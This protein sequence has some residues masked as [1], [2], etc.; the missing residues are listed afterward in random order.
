[1]VFACLANVVFAGTIETGSTGGGQAHNNRQSYL[2]MNHLVRLQGTDD[3][4][5]EIG[6]FA[7]NFAPSGWALADGQILQVSQ[8]QA[9]HSKLGFTYGGN[10]TTTFA[11]PDLR[12]RT[13]IGTGQGF[14]M[15]NRPLGTQ[16]GTSTVSLSTNQLPSHNHAV[17]GAIGG[18][19]TTVGG[20]QSHN[21][22]MPS[23]ALTQA[24][25]LT[26]LIPSRGLT[27]G[28]TTIDSVSTSPFI[29]EIRTYAG[30]S[31][32]TGFA[33]TNGQLLPI[34]QNSDLFS[35][36]GTSYGGDGETTTGLPNLQGRTAMHAGSGPGLT[37][38]KI[39]E[40]GGRKMSR[41]LSIK[42]HF[43]LTPF[44]VVIL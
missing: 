8:F 19:T 16:V 37:P 5:G 1:M 21:N 40:T 11:L 41:C 31:I 4:L 18:V 34:S 24:I 22:M 44:R 3:E 2:V 35:I 13:I 25:A 9:L 43:T 38:R 29:A 36:I 17:S 6:M 15:Q 23:L 32:P 20:D 26:G 12:G 42:S 7:G 39:S 10:G 28:L 27:A 33:A 14:E 30:S